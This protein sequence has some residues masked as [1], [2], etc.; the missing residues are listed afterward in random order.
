MVYKPVFRNPA[1]YRNRLQEKAIGQSAVEFLL[2]APLLFTILFAIIQVAYIAYASLAVQRAALSIAKDV[3][4]TDGILP[5]DPEFQLLYSLAPLG[6]LN[7]QTLATIDATQCTIQT[8]E[9]KIHVEVR[10]PMPIWIPLVRN[11]MGEKLS[12]SYLH[13]KSVSDMMNLV[14]K[15]IDKTPP[16]LPLSNDAQP[17]VHW[18]T[19]S[20][21]AN[22]ENSI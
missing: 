6:S 11:F 19:F 16:S 12:S 21:D 18:I 3:A 14:F 15:I 10:Y 7:S 9:N 1:I 4:R 17:V 22:D 13:D 2:I 8:N 20:A 5:Y